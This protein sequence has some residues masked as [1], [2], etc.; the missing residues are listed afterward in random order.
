MKAYFRRLTNTYLQIDIEPADV[1]C[2][3]DWCKKTA[4]WKI[5]NPVIGVTKQI[6]DVCKKQRIV[7]GRDDY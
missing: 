5:T 6:C 2:K 3:C 1:D 7:E 4:T